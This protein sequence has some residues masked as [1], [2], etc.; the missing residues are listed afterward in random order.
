MRGLARI[1]GQDQALKRLR[2]FGDHF[3]QR[4]RAPDHIAL[5]GAEGM[6]KSAIAR[7]LAEELDVGIKLT[8]APLL[9]KKGDLTAI[10]TSLEA[11]DILFLGDVHRLRQPLKEIL[12]PALREFRIGLVIGQGPSARIHPYQLNRFTCVSSLQREGDLTPELRDSFPLVLKLQPYPS[13]ELSTIAQRIAAENSIVLAPSAANLI[14]VASNGSPHQAELLVRRIATGERKNVSEADAQKYF[15]ILGIGSGESGSPDL[16]TSLDVLSGSEF[17]RLIG[18]LLSR[19]EFQ[20]EMTRPTGDGG[21]DIIA[22]LAKTFV[23]G[24]FLIQCKRY[25]VGNSVGAPLIR[26]FYGALTADPSAVKGI[27][28]TTSNF[29]DQARAFAKDLALELIDREKL[30]HLLREFGLS[31]S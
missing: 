23:G 10:L 26:E 14:A 18:T 25:A 22:T 16:V 24:R 12:I 29:T 7:S 2:E 1:V 27:F 4:G 19:M 5:V 11:G 17:E 28:I 13:S 21:V 30:Q 6:G 9:E 15:S 8:T 20:I 3:L 31:P